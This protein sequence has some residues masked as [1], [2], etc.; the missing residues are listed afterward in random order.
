MGQVSTEW[1]PATAITSDYLQESTDVRLVSGGHEH[2]VLKEP[3]ER[4]VVTLLW[5]QQRQNAVEFEEE[6]SGAL[7][8]IDIQ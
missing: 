2:H 6:P 7:C 8:W 4:T 5:L 1:S 3:K